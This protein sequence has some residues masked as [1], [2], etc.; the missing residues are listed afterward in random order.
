MCKWRLANVGNCQYHSFNQIKSK[1]RYNGRLWGNKMWCLPKYSAANA[2]HKASTRYNTCVHLMASRKDCLCRLNQSSYSTYRRLNLF[3]SALLCVFSAYSSCSR[4]WSRL[5]VGVRSVV[6]VS[7][8][9]IRETG[10][11]PVAQNDS[12]CDAR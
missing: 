4:C 3:S 9:S 5:R 6:S 2:F 7:V 12:Y 1:K 8:A 10:R 11:G